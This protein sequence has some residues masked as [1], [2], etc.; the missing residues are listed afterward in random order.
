VRAIEPGGY[1]HR[2]VVAALVHLVALEGRP[3]ED[4]KH[5]LLL[6]TRHLGQRK[7]GSGT[8]SLSACADHDDHRVSANQRLDIAARLLE[9]LPG[10]VGVVA[11]AEMC[12]RARADQ[13]AFGRRHVRKRELIGIQKPHRH[14]VVQTLCVGR[15]RLFGDRDVAI[16]QRLQRPQ[17]VPATATGTQKKDPHLAPASC[18][19]T[20]R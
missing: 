13:Q 11:R 19:P 5:Q 9:R 15:I 8:C 17:D 20:V 4:R 7:D 18:D 10:H 2:V 3:H 16:E 6:L 14:G 1:L 12:R